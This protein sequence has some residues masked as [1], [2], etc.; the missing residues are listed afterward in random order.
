MTP[1]GDIVWDF[2]NPKRTGVD[3]ELIASLLEV[4]RIEPGYFSTEFTAARN[5]YST[6]QRKVDQTAIDALIKKL[7]G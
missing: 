5:E 2:T 4:V 3:N 7:G 1:E 6:G